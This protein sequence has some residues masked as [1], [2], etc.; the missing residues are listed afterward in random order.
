MIEKN[1]KSLLLLAA[2]FLVLIGTTACLPLAPT[3]V[4]TTHLVPEETATHPPI[5]TTANTVTTVP[6]AT[7]L[8]TQAPSPTPT[9]SPSLTQT[10]PAVII[11]D[12][13]SEVGYN[14]PLTIQHVSETEATLFFELETP[15]D[16]SMLYWPAAHPDQIAVV[17]FSPDET[18]HQVRL[19][20]LLPGNQYQAVVGLSAEGDLYQPP[21]FRGLD[22]GSV[23]LNTPGGEEPLRIGVIGDSGLGESSTLAL[24]EQMAAHDLDFVLHTGDVVYLMKDHSD[25]FE[26]YAEKYY[27]PLAPL[28]HMLPIYTVVGNHDIE[29][30]TL[31]EDQPFYYYAFPPFLTP[32]FPTSDFNG[33][34]QWYAIAFGRI[35]F[36]ML[37]TQTLFGEDG[38]AEQTL[39]LEERL[40][41]ER[42]DFT[43]P[44]FH[45]PPF[46]SGPHSDEGPIVEQLWGHLFKPDQIPVVFS[47]HEHFYERLEVDGIT[48]VI[49]GGGTSI[50]YNKVEQ[51]SHSQV[52]ARQMH[53]VLIEIYTGRIEIKAITE[54]GELLDQFDIPL[55]SPDS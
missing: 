50:L 27:Q 33:K 22:W 38:L 26:A 30:A 17:P 48:Y 15:A 40:A 20:G 13:F 46:S 8:P 7:L 36:L 47:G 44:V 14:L 32:T 35:Q 29:P 54:A 12:T 21:N 10:P 3:V 39:W 24:A 28:L 25:P 31:W 34:N 37:D 9:L 11:A 1:K 4:P 45:V 18:R 42:F 2:V 19:E 55:E 41:D 49:S 52:Y 6:T 23:N 53:F 5:V 16:G 43:I 51:H